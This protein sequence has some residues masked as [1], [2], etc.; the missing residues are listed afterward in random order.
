MRWVGFGTDPQNNGR[1]GRCKKKRVEK[2]K[3]KQKEKVVRPL[4]SKRKK[5]Q[6]SRETAERAMRSKSISIRA[7]KA[8]ISGRRKPTA[9]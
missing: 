5:S 6:P 9:Q 1:E 4:S 3:R 7:R 8:S 2:K